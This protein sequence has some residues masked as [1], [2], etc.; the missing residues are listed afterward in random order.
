MS[1]PMTGGPEGAVKKLR[2]AHC[3]LGVS[4]GTAMARALK[5]ENREVTIFESALPPERVEPELAR[6]REA[7]EKAH[8]QLDALTKKMQETAG[9][10]Y[11]EIFTAH[12]LLLK[13]PAFSGKMEKLIRSDRT[14]AEWAVQKIG[15][16]AAQVLASL[17]DKTL[18]ERA[19]DVEDVRN[20]LLLNLTGGRDNLVHRLTEDVIIVARNLSPSDTA[21]LHSPHI[22]GFVT[23]LGGA[24]SHTAIIAK[25]LGIPAVVGLHNFSAGLPADSLLAID[26]ATGEVIVGPDAGDRADF[27]AREG[28]FAAQEE[29]NLRAVTLPSETRD[30]V[31]IALRANLELEEE[32][33]PAR[34]HGAEGVGLY[35]SEF[36][37]LNHSP[38]IPSEAD[39]FAV[40]DRFAAAFL[41]QPV[42]IRTL[43]LG[44]EKY[45]HSVLDHNQRNPVL[46]LRAIRLCLKRPDIF[47]AQLLGI[48]RAS[49]RGNV[50]LMFPLITTVSE[51]REAKGLLEEARVELRKRGEAFDEKMPVGIMIEVPSA[52]MTADILARE[53][54]F[55]AI[56]TNDLI[57]YLLAIDRGNEEVGYLYSPFHPAVLRALKTTFDA[58]AAAG[59]PVSL[60]GE[61][62][63]DPACAEMLL[64]LGLREFSMHP[65]SIPAIKTV[66]RETS[67]ADAQARAKVAL[68][69]STA[70]EVEAH[71][72]SGKAGAETEK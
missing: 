58:A 26:G 39:H 57:S 19:A 59:I 2:T 69:L 64:G 16:E 13:D 41:P 15:D 37:F 42:T 1:A 11:A 21:M 72:R 44:G 3:G 6:L 35:R 33:L 48:L 28:R 22:A 24:T 40:Y 51:L 62:G 32:I 60:C 66:I 9:D 70:A 12:Q 25:A 61:I 34:Q 10:S 56:G 53:S 46:G 38:D 17:G 31:H 8:A 63:A 29:K 14:T 71:F 54:D 55:F 67:I 68:S 5:M 4:P 23:D 49:R 30:G 36:L 45:F 7:I 18:R 50:R 43:D 52:V 27:T 20:R 65:L 47:R